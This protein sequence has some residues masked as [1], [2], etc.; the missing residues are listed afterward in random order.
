METTRRTS[1]EGLFHN[2]HMVFH[3]FMF[4]LMK[5]KKFRMRG[6]GGNS[7]VDL[8]SV[9]G[10]AGIDDLYETAGSAARTVPGAR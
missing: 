6:Y 2:I 10:E 1:K 8:P 9:T 7:P 5:G 3:T 4:T